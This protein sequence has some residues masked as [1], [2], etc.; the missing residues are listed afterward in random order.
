MSKT[1]AS[2]YFFSP[3]SPF[4]SPHMWQSIVYSA[5]LPSL[6]QAGFLK[7]CSTQVK[8]EG[9]CCLK[10]SVVAPTDTY[11]IMTALPVSDAGCRHPES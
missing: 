9:K 7:L 5:L 10:V 2:I 11:F 1:S 4:F 8:L 6:Y 3:F